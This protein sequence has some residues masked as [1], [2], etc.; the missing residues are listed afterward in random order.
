MV[1]MMEALKRRIPFLIVLTLVVV[2]TAVSEMEHKLAYIAALVVVMVTTSE[3][4][5]RRRPSR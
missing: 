5:I 1:L 3:L 2:V 4:V